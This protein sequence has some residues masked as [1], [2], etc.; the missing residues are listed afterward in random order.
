SVLPPSIQAIDPSPQVF[1]FHF[2][3]MS[4]DEDFAG[5]PLHI[6]LMLVVFCIWLFLFRKDALLSVYT[7]GLIG[8]A[9]LFALIV[10]W[11]PWITRFHLP[12]FVLASVW[13]GVILGRLKN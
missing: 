3:E 9:L 1:E 10:C 8:A 13:M 4:S 12:F 2:P 6:V 11:Q 7:G 5:N